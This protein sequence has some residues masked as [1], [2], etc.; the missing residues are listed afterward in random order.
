MKTH[1]YRGHEFTPENTYI[2][3]SSGK[4]RCRQCRLWRDR[5]RREAARQQPNC[6][7]AEVTDYARDMS[8]PTDF[9]L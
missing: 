7:R 3:P 2:F 9:P 4:A 8:L 6:S 1:C 5:K